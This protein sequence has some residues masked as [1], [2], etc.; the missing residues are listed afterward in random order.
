LLRRGQFSE[1]NFAN[2]GESGAVE[3][4]EVFFDDHED[5][6]IRDGREPE[7]RPAFLAWLMGDWLWG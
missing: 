3:N 5:E 4:I 1:Q 7:W 2:E 6:V